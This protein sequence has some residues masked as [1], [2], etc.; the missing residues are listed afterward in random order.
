MNR[1]FIFSAVLFTLLGCEQ[2]RSHKKL[3]AYFDLDSLLNQQISEL[4]KSGVT[5]QKTVTKDGDTESRSFTPDST[6]WQREFAMIRQFNL[7]KPNFVG[8]YT[9]EAS[10]EELVYVPKYQDKLEIKDFQRAY[11]DDGKLKSLA[12]RFESDKYLYEVQQTVNLDFQGDLIKTFNI[13]GR[14]K[15]IMLDAVE[16]QFSGTIIK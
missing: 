10:G 8:S 6:D 14:Q 5:L 7:N 12:I 1:I 2:D 13:S 3:Q 16:Y 15:M 4:V 9:L 11:T